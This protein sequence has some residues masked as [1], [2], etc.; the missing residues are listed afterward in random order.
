MKPR[1]QSGSG[2]LVAPRV[3]RTLPRK[4]PDRGENACHMVG[5]EVSVRIMFST[6]SLAYPNHRINQPK[7]IFYGTN[8]AVCHMET[9]APAYGISF[10]A[11]L[12][13]FI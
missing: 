12:D 1:G 6:C 9:L 3:P 4:I 2:P 7:S 13:D 8:S 11:A 5:G 10:H